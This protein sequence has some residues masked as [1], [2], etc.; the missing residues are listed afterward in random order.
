MIIENI[1]FTQA[2]TSV[3]SVL[4]IEY[5]KEAKL[6]DIIHDSIKR[7]E[8]TYGVTIDKDI[9]R[10]QA[11]H[12]LAGNMLDKFLMEVTECLK[13]LA[14]YNSLQIYNHGHGYTL[15][16]VNYLGLSRP[17]LLQELKYFMDKDLY[18]KREKIVNSLKQAV[19]N[20]PLNYVKRMFVALFLFE[21]LGIVEGVAILAQLL[22]MG[23][24][25]V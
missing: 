16:D 10:L 20:V 13:Q 12:E 22:Y 15:A 24:L 9:Y 19:D 11:E 25:I 8:D 18:S 14:L 5:S 1:S 2:L 21:K 7:L 4:K 17:N 6:A 23:G 3:E